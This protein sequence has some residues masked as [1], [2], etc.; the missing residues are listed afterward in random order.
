MCLMVCVPLLIS[1]TAFQSSF[2]SLLLASN[3]RLLMVFMVSCIY[4]FRH[5]DILCQSDNIAF[6]G[7]ALSCVHKIMDH[8]MPLC[9]SVV[10]V[11]AVEYVACCMLLLCLLLRSDFSA[12]SNTPWVDICSLYSSSFFCVC[13]HFFDYIPL[14]SSVGQKLIWYMLVQWNW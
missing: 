12:A 13:F 2:N 5:F 7:A 8:R 1:L 3:T 11:A 9:L 4:F 14:T 6:V 10:A